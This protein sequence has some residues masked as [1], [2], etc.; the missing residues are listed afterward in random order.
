MLLECGEGDFGWG[1]LLWSPMIELS[2]GKGRV[3]LCQVEVAANAARVPG[4]CVLLRNLLAYACTPRKAVGRSLKVLAGQA[5]V[6]SHLL[7]DAGMRRA[8]DATVATPD[9]VVADADSLDPAA[10][11][12][13]SRMMHEGAE[14][15]VVA[16]KP[17]HAALL[18]RL[19]G[20]TLGVV[21]APVHQVAAQPD[22]ATRGV[23]PS[24][25]SLI[26]K[27][28]YSPPTAD[29][30]VIARYAVEAASASPLLSG[31][32]APWA[33]FFIKGLDA[34]YLKTAVATMAADAPLPAR[35]Y[36]A[37]V[38]VGTGALL[39]CQV[40]PLRGNERVRRFYAQ[41]LWNLGVRFDSS[42]F[43]RLPAAS[44]YGL[45]A[46]MALAREAHH[47]ARAMEVYFTDPNYTLNN[48]G[49]GVFGWM[50]RIDA[51]G[52]VI[53]IPQS[54]GKTWYLTVFIESEGPLHELPDPGIVPDLLLRSSG[55]IR[56]FLNGRVLRDMPAAP[57]GTVTIADAVLSKGIN[58][59][60][61][62]CAAG[63][64]DVTIS[65]WFRTKHGE[66]V[67]G[68]R[69]LLTLD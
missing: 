1:G 16:A 48:L 10:G 19:A 2:V 50:K 31:V 27:V 66:P 11:A 36:G 25:L 3:L 24:D 18:G 14:V 33:D 55:P 22:P 4:A 9:L 41:L 30:T 62:I 54:A 15:L 52:G 45:E 20:T 65:A 26:D 40:L 42:F 39:V 44:D 63:A 64:D 43:D 47:D 49:E 12:S 21:E 32:T 61:F 29:N 46:V 37:R 60:L 13:L 68:V 23:S 8:E 34:E 7:E 69:S 53:T 35:C 58:R 57:G 38:Q 6:L 28:T 5:G 51:R 56:V 17:R 67:P 59:L